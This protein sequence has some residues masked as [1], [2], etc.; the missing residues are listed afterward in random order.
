M[1]QTHKCEV[2]NRNLIKN[3]RTIEAQNTTAKGQIRKFTSS[4]SIKIK[5]N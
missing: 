2:S 3:I 1:N 4:I 5:M